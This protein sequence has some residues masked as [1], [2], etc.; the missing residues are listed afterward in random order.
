M[1]PGRAALVIVDVQ[2]AAIS[3]GPYRKDEVVENIA[4][5]LDVS[6]GSGVEVVYVQH[7]GASGDEYE[8]GTPGWEIYRAIEPKPGEKVVRKR[9]NSGFRETGLR[10]HL[11]ERGVGT[12]VLVGIQTEYC[13]DTTCRVAFEFGFDIVIPEM[14]NTTYDTDELSARQIH[15]HYNR[16]IWD[17]RFATVRTMAD[18]LK[19]LDGG[20]G[21]A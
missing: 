16:R 17:G 18:T 3:R 1:S 4:A 19:A 20:G 2:E 13:V 7:D 12:I 8:P 6:R 5:L 9:F 11:E 14:T 10:A 15:D 21:F